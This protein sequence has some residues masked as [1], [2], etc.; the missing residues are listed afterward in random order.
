[1]MA[2]SESSANVDQRRRIIKNEFGIAFKKG[3]R[4]YFFSRRDVTCGVTHGARALHV[5]AS[6][7]PMNEIHSQKQ[8]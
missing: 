6:Q 8:G 7:A 2:N 4:K 1:M 5:R 3:A